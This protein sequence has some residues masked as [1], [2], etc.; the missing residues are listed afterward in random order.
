MFITRWTWWT[1]H[2]CEVSLA[3]LASG[4]R[5]TESTMG[6]SQQSHVWCTSLT[7]LVQTQ[8][9]DIINTN[10]GVLGKYFYFP[11]ISE[12][13][14]WDPVGVQGFEVVNS[15]KFGGGNFGAASILLALVW[16]LHHPSE[17]QKGL[18][19]LIKLSISRK[20]LFHPTKKTMCSSPA[21][22]GEHCIIVKFRWHFSR[23]GRV[24]QSRQWEFP[25]ISRMM[26]I[27]DI[28]NT[29]TN[30]W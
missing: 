21:G 29:N 25:T 1:L 28:I 9:I 26:H 23:Q 5:V 14:N 15:R 8:I 13:E 19:S 12:Y 16:G 6:N 18:L 30:S 17:S 11:Q 4:S 7:L 10:A 24:W 2:Y 3:P 27:I 22:P 20:I